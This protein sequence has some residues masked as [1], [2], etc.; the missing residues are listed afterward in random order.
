MDSCP[1]ATG[2]PVAACLKPV[3]ART[4]HE[5]KG[6]GGGIRACSRRGLL[7]AA[8]LKRSRRGHRTK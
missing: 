8:C 6:A 4:P 5:V 2:L 1:L 3:V 7:V